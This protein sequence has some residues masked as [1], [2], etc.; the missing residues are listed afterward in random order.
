MKYSSVWPQEFGCG[1]CSSRFG[2]KQEKPKWAWLVPESCNKSGVF[3]ALASFE[4]VYKAPSH[5]VSS[6][7]SLNTF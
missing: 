4:N 5:L 6:Q 2:N 3:S 1:W 7:F